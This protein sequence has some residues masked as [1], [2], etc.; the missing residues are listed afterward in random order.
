M[1][2]PDKNRRM[3]PPN[4]ELPLSTTQVQLIKEWIVQGARWETHWAFTAPV[5]LNDPT[6]LESARVLA[7]RVILQAGR[8][9]GRTKL[10]CI[11][12]PSMVTE[13]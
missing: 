12:T 4:A 9:P 11:F 1:S 6:Y 2:N 3:L 7:E 5:L 8:D 10:S 13:E